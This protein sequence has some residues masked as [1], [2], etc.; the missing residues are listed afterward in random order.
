MS[1]LRFKLSC[2]AL[3][4]V[5]LYGIALYRVVLFC[6]VSFSGLPRAC[7]LSQ[8]FG[9][10]GHFSPRPCSTTDKWA[11][12]SAHRQNGP[13]PSV[14]SCP[15]WP[16]NRR[17]CGIAEK[18]ASLHWLAQ[19]AGYVQFLWPTHLD[20]LQSVHSVPKFVLDVRFTPRWAL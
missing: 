8:R 9:S 7:C 12:L 19:A 20:A 3:S 1:S 10:Y 14:L 13:H 6:V 4:C 17:M 18:L 16:L 11:K 5:V 2:V 15:L